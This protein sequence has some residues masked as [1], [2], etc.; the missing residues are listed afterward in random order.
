M[1]DQNRTSLLVHLFQAL[2]QIEPAIGDLIFF[3]LFNSFLQ[4]NHFV[5]DLRQGFLLKNNQKK[6]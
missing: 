6:C 2:G 5:I 1:Y 4:G 3:R